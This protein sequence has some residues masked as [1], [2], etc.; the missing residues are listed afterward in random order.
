MA[1]ILSNSAGFEDDPGPQLFED[2][3]PGSTFYDWINRLGNRGIM[4]GYPCGGPGEACGPGNMP[5][6]RPGNTTT[7]GQVTKLVSNTA[8]YND[9]PTGQLF[10][11]VAPGSTFYP[12]VYRLAIRSIMSGYACD[13]VPNAPCVPPSNLPYFMPSNAA[14]RAQVTKI[15]SGALL[16][17]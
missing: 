4:D 14:T 13:S 10:E 17:P 15:V 5:Y 2:V 9:D 12:Y 1:K 3:P 11:D 8:G 7:R 6:F 16:A